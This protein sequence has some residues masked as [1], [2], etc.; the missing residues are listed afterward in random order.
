MC[1]SRRWDRTDRHHSIAV[2]DD[3]CPPRI[4]SV[5]GRRRD[6]VGASVP[7]HPSVLD[8]ELATPVSSHAPGLRPR[9]EDSVLE[10]G[11]SPG[12]CHDR[13]KLP[14][15]LLDRGAWM[16]FESR[17]LIA[18][19]LVRRWSRPIRCPGGPGSWLVR[20]VG[21]PKLRRWPFG[22]RTLPVSRCRREQCPDA[23]DRPPSSARSRTSASGPGCMRG[24]DR[25]FVVEIR[26]SGIGTGSGRRCGPCGRPS[27]RQ[28][29][30]RSRGALQR[31]G[32]RERCSA[33]VLLVLSVV[34]RQ[35]PHHRQQPTWLSELAWPNCPT[36][37][38]G[39]AACAAST[40]RRVAPARCLAM[41]WSP[42]T[43][44]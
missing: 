26:H 27:F 20:E 36:V 43:T 33:V 37:N 44:G 42:A 31:N 1:P 11:D 35:I 10:P 23:V 32:V 4:L 25:A 24:V 7:V 34:L 16:G 21:T 40:A 17:R 41:L 15:E 28:S 9:V 29:D 2:I 38:C 39:W 3:D 8:A 13:G 30:Q 14:E 12:P 5:A 22:C 19:C 18:M 6:A